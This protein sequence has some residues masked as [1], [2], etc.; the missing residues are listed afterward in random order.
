MSGTDRRSVLRLAAAALLVP[1]ASAA[2][3]ALA[4]SVGRFTPPAGPMLYTRRL[5]RGLRDGASSGQPAFLGRVPATGRRIPRRR[6]TSRCG[7][8]RAGGLGGVRPHRA[9]APGPRVTATVERAIREAAARIEA[10]GDSSGEKA[11]L[12]QFV[13]VIHQTA[14]KLVSEL[15]VDLFAP[16]Q[17]RRHESREVSLPGGEA[18]EV[19]VLFNARSDPAT[20]VMQEAVREVV[21][22][23]GGDQRRTV[24]SWR[25]APV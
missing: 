8:E 6:T 13:A 18:G 9:R 21:T 16:V 11:L 4:G 17:S 7:C 10:L 23:L 15:P 25:L 24:E 5:E 22:A 19:T 14:G 12:Q 20:G 1:I 3:G 2:T